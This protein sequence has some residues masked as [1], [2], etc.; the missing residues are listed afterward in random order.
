MK[1]L[2]TN[3]DGV[4][5][6]GIRTLFEYLKKDHDV[7]I[8]AT[9]G[10]RSGSSMSINLKGGLQFI[11]K[12]DGI[13]ACTG[14]PA[15]C[16]LYSLKGAVNFKPEAVVSGINVGPNLGTDLLY[17][18]TAAAARQGTLLGLP[19]LAVSLDLSEKEPDFNYSARF[20]RENLNSLLS[21]WK[22]DNFVNLNF[23]A[24]LNKNPEVIV[25]DLAHRSYGN[26]IIPFAVPRGD[27]W[28]FLH[29]SPVRSGL[30]K[31]TDW[32]TVARGHISLTPVAVYPE[33]SSIEA[34][35]VQSENVSWLK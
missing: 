35:R 21:F 5:S 29:G 7:I 1:L 24:V 25:T 22:N 3:D 30:Y 16:V 33:T 14:S 15:D 8:A 9:D 26:E 11:K 27:T 2:L 18:G 19:S 12:Q 23:P 28:Y 13:F 17:S 34:F 4:E 6:S 32:E 20:I 31:G 10:D